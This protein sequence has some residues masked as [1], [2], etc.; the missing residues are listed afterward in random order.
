[1]MFYLNGDVVVDV[2][3]T[4]AVWKHTFYGKSFATNTK[5]ENLFLFK[6]LKIR[7]DSFKRNLKLFKSIN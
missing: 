4:S 5:I 1:M 6:K 7:F 3:D 2:I